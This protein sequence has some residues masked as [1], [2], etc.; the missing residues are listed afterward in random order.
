[1]DASLETTS[2]SAA[3]APAETSAFNPETTNTTQS[4]ARA[5]DFARVRS[6]NRYAAATAEW[7]AWALIALYFLGAAA[8]GVAVLYY[9]FTR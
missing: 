3:L 8:L 9:T 6:L 4:I 2:V 1:M 7:L 5:I